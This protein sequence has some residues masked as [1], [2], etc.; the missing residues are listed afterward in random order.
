MRLLHLIDGLGP[1]GAERSLVEMIPALQ[2]RGF[3]SSVVLLKESPHSMHQPLIDRGIPVT[4]LGTTSRLRQVRSLRRAIRTSAPDLVWTTL[5]DSTILGRLA[6]IGLGVPV[7]TSIVNTSYLPDRTNHHVRYRSLE[8]ARRIDAVT[9][10]RLSSHFHAITG[11]VKAHA[12]STLGI[13][14]RSVAVVPR[15]R[16]RSRLGEPSAHRRA[17]ARADLGVGDDEFLVLNVGRQ[18]WQKGQSTLLEST[19]LL[20]GRA[21]KLRV[22]V[23][24]RIGTQT[25]ALEAA[26]HE[27]G[28]AEIVTFLGQRDDVPALLCAAD[29]FVFPSRFE[30][31]GGS[32][33]EAMAMETPVIASDIPALREVL[34]DGALGVLVAVDDPA[35]LADAIEEVLRDTDH[36]HAVAVRARETVDSKYEFESVMDEMATWLRS[37]W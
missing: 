18:E 6:S 5:F 34:D 3:D 33:L 4:I 8:L 14:P 31:L 30:G 10:R 1:G 22:A 23:A 15:G 19:A 24:G 36:R 17:N 35:A 29:V 26:C 7:V 20:R 28:V 21:P 25:A 27:L 11:A 32:V 12:V 13:D 2:L 16:D 37:C 9:A